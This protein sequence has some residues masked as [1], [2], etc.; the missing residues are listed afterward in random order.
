MK[1]FTEKEMTA[2]ARAGAVAEEAMFN[3]KIVTAFAGQ[4]KE[5][6]RYLSIYKSISVLTL[7]YALGDELA[8]KYINL[9]TR[10][11]AFLCCYHA[12]SS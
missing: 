10:Y 9:G 4:D 8:I 11:L 6:N 12:S 7:H 5:G 2:Y 3:I 1:I